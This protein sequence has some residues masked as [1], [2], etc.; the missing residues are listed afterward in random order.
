[1]GASFQDGYRVQV[2]IEAINQSSAKGKRVE[3]KEV[4]QDI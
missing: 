2:V 3:I 4:G 1:L